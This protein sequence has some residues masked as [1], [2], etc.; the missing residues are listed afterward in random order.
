[1]ILITGATGLTGRHLLKKLL[2]G[3]TPVRALYRTEER[4]AEILNFL[5]EDKDSL[6]NLQLL[7]WHQADINDIPALTDAFEDVSEV[8]H[9]AG[10]V[11]FDIRDKKRLRKIN[12]EGTANMVNIALSKQVQKFCHV[13]SVAALGE[14]IDGKPI[15][16]NSERIKAKT[17]NY[18]EISKYGAEMEVWR[19][20]QEGLDVIIVN[21]AIIIGSGN[22]TSGS[23]RLFHQ[24]AKG[25]PLLIPKESGFVSV[26]DVVEAMV[27]LMKSPIKNERYILVSEVQSFAEITRQ[28]ALNM[29]VKPPHIKLRKWMLFLLWLGQSIGFIFGKSK[30]INLRNFSSFYSKIQFDNSKIQQHL[31]FSFTPINKAIQETAQ[32]YQK[33]HGI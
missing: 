2:E 23:G 32:A 16:E 6:L 10:L 18:Y 28:I 25:F 11:S 1:M 22:W 12:I 15:S 24:T 14:E 31:N 19:A 20:S 17:Y 21:P 3:E 13:S 8:Y 30:E 7:N 26:K 5:K 33:E 27:Q 4:K 29:N 9:C